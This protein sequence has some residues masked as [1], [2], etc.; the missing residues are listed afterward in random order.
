MAQAGG[1][2]RRAPRWALLCTLFGALIML[3]S[4]GVLVGYEVLKDRYA[5]E[6]R[7]LFGGGSGGEE[8]PRYGEDIEGPLNIL[9]AGL[10][11]RPSRPEEPARADA[12]LIVHIPEGMDRG[13]LISL[14][15]DTLVD[16]PAFEETGYYGGRDR[17]NAAM[18]FG[19]QQVDGEE[20]PN[21]ERG[22]A[23]LAETVSGL[24]G[25]EDFDAGAV[26]RFEGFE[27]I[28]DALG[29]I[30]VELEEEIV[31][32]HRQPDGT[33][34]PLGCGSFCGPQMVY[35]P[36]TPPCG[37]AGSGGRFTCELEGWHALDIARQRYGLAEGDYGRQ[38][39]QQIILKG[40]MDEAFSRDVVTNPVALDRLIRAGG[41]A[42]IF[43]GRGREPIDFAF[44]LRGVRPGSVVSLTLPA[45]NIGSGGGY[46]GEEL[47]QGAYD[48]FE[49]IQADR[50]DEFVLA[51]P[52]MVA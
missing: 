41:D 48:L 43:D 8:Q 33:H 31:S 47:Q 35:Q 28:V 11:T 21:L 12:V 30:S 52:D 36:D 34:R 50:V 22:F 44:A 17:L 26:V 19:S 39:N 45:S 37:E 20:L 46:Q 25:I 5:V 1:L 51:H 18:F 3:G 27:D 23:L 29:G 40:I 10:D 38:A 2:V 14:P 42:L 7:D 9:L 15:R 4:G 49:A 32:E 16:I 6:Q 13:Y 24:T